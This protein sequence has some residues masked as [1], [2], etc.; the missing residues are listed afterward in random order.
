MIPD[1]LFSD[2]IDWKL[3]ADNFDEMLKAAVSI[4]TG[5]LLPS[6]ILR[7]TRFVQSSAGAAIM[8]WQS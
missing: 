1:A 7:R 2:R 8:S 3:I 4:K 5:K 6:T